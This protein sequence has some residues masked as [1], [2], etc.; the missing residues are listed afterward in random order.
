ME[1]AAAVGRYAYYRYRGESG[2]YPAARKIAANFYRP[3]EDL[4]A[5]QDKAI[6][7]IVNH[8]YSKSRYYRK[9]YDAVGFKPGDVKNRADLVKLPEISKTELSQ[10]MNDIITMPREDLERSVTGGTT[11]VQLT[12]YRDGATAVFRRALDLVVPRYYGWQDGQW[13]GWLWGATMDMVEPTSLKGRIVLHF[14][15]RTYFVDSVHLNHESYVQFMKR[16]REFR[17]TYISAYP[18]IAYDLAE[19][20]ADGDIE[21]LRFRM[22]SLTAEPTYPFQRKLIA[23]HLADH[24]FE[25]YGSRECGMAALECPE[26][27]GMHVFTES[28]YFETVDRGPNAPGSDILQ[29]DLINRAMPVIRY[30]TGDVGE[31]DDAPCACGRTSQRIHSIEGRETDTIWRR[32]GSGVAGP[33]IAAFVGDTRLKVPVQVI[34][35]SRD[36]IRVRIEDHSGRYDREVKALL[37]RFRREIGDYIA[38]D[39]EHVD[40]IERAA[41]GKYRYVISK[42]TRKEAQ[43][44]GARTD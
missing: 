3:L 33:I 35:E 29:T 23:E 5:E 21:P 25:R 28:V 22:I 26:H 15:N 8:A 19:R 12:Y 13:Q 7:A 27:N 6:E 36:H 18:S 1:L 39:L 24:V 2:I 44:G 17:P 43:G 40:R 20:I 42:I 10:N 30:H 16:T 4:L 32:D 9:K 11:G 37:E 41:S 31:I 14:G 38:Y 34:Q